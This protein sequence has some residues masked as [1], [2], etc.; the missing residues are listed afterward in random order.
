MNSELT[1][2]TDI[3]ESPAECPARKL[4]ENPYLNPPQPTGRK[5]AGWFRGW[6]FYDGDS[7]P[8]PL[9]PDG[10]IQY[11][12]AADFSFYPCRQNG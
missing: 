12:A 3:R 7:R 10:S 11:F 8:A 1:E 4:P 5:S 9:R 2:K 6:I